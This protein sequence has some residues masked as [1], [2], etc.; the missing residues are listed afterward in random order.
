MGRY[1]E[2]IEVLL[3]TL[4]YSSNDIE[5]YCLLGSYYLTLNKI[6]ES[7]SKYMQ[8]LKINNSDPRIYIGIGNF[9]YVYPP[10]LASSLSH[11]KQAISLLNN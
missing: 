6:E 8:A 3:H 5:I 9:Y 7:L 11:Y 2:A 4:N 1:N 10:N